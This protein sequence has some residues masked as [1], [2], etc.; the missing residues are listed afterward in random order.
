MNYLHAI[1]TIKVPQCKGWTTRNIGDTLLDMDNE[2]LADAGVWFQKA[3]EVDTKN[4]FWLV[5]VM[6][7]ACYV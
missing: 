5:L 3:I 6:D 2:P 7:C 4:G 1:K